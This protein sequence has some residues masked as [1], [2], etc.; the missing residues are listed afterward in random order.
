MRFG[1]LG[2]GSRGSIGEGIEMSKKRKSEASRLDE[3]DRT[4][5]S[6]FSSAANSLSQ[7]YTQAMHHQKLSFQAGERHALVRIFAL[8]FDPD[9]L[10][11]FSF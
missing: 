5:Y 9:T 10:F 7:L 4:M 6:A 2:F 11:G 8:S 3:I 1:G